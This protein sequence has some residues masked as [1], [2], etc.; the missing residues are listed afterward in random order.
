MARPP[1]FPIDARGLTVRFGQVTAISGIDI[2]IHGTRRLAILGA[3]GAGKSV[4]LRTLHG[5]IPPTEGTVTWCGS[6]LRPS[7]QAMVFQRPVMLRRTA[8][9]NV[10][11]ALDV[12]GVEGNERETRTREALKRV[13]LTSIANRQARVLSFG[14]QQRLALARAW[15]LRPR[16]L[17]LD[18]PTSSLDPTAAAEVERVIHEIQ[19]AGTTIVVTTHVL[20]FARRIADEIVF[21]HMG[22]LLERT[23]ADRF[24]SNPQ[25]PEAERFLKGELPWNG[26]SRR[27]SAG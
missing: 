3:N 10:Q 27:S 9:A 11:Y 1:I 24:F 8:L 23:P 14:E 5:L 12:H 26:I 22:R 18:E 17:Y 13:G 4:L 6:T 16:I 7:D 20:G 19:V 15:A 25:T 2:S 21:L